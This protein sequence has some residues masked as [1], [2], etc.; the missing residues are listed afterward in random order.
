M[1]LPFYLGPFTLSRRAWMLVAVL[2]P[3]LLVFAWVAF[4]SGPLAPVRVTAVTVGERAIAPALFG[5]GTVEARYTQRIGPTAPGRVASLA[6][7]VGDRVE[8]GQLIAVIDPIDLDQRIEAASGSA[9]R[10]AAL[11]QAAASQIADARARLELARS[12]A[13]RGEELF[14]GGW[15]TRTAL[16]QRRQAL[17][18]A[19]AG[20]ATAQ[21]N[22][23]A[24]TQDRGRTGAE[25]AALLEQKANLR[26]VAPRAGLVV[27]RLAEPGT[28]VVAGQAVIEV[29]DPSELWI[30]ARFDQS[31]AGGISSGL[32]A[33]IVLRSRSDKPLKGSVLRIEPVA[34]AVTEEVLAKVAFD[35]S[36]SL[37]PIGE[38]AEVTVGLPPQHKTLALPNA[39]IHRID[40]ELGVWVIRDG[41]PEFVVV[42]LGAED[43]EGWVQVL[44]GLAKGEQVVLHS[45]RPLGSASRLSIV[46]KL[47]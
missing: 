28:T 4:R 34:D 30:N 12:E 21:A 40:G 3:L 24:A 43:A 15:L 13:A 25:R 22:R 36:A 9:G 45:A 8:V 33:R 39:A 35:G 31:R 44:Q 27:R 11:E 14:R 16:D 42:K 2:V 29:V 6:V 32:P 46:D 47:P 26:L 38:L 41:D 23:T 7:D 10:S 1:T 17:A 5:I 20:L 18:A 37:P 19:Q